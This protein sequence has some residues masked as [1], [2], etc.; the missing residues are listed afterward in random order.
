MGMTKEERAEYMRDYA[1]N[2]AGYFVEKQ[3]LWAERNRDKVLAYRRA[4]YRRHIEREREKARKRYHARTEEQKEQRRT[5]QREYY[6][7]QKL[8]LIREE[9]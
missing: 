3:M 8:K 2:N 4:Y 1:K 5:Y 9:K 7:K 6:Y